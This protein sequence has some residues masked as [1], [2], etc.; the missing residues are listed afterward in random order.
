MEG[1]ERVFSPGHPYHDRIFYDR[2]EGSYYDRCTD[3]FLTLDEVRSFGL[4]V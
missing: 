3:L 1:L 2:L 4:P